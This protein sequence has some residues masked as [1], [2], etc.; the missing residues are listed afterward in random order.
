M[1][2]IIRSAP[3]CLT[4]SQMQ[5]TRLSLTNFRNLAR[6]DIDVPPGTTLILGKNAQGKT[7]ILE[8]IFFLATMST[9][10]A[11]SDRQLINLIHASEAAGCGRAL[12]VSSPKAGTPTRSRCASSR[13]TPATGITRARKEVLVDGVKKPAREAIGQFN[14]V[15]FLPQ[16]MRVVEGPPEERRRY[17][18]LA[19]S[20]VVPHAATALNEYAKVVSNRNALLKRLGESGGDPEQLDFWDERLAKRGAEI[21]H[22][23]IQAVQE[24]DLTARTIHHD[25]TGGSEI[26]R[27]DYQPSYDPADGLARSRP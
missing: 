26:L 6:V 7:S 27:L 25:I 8:A 4:A 20:Q 17:L 21:I 13:K 10:H 24:L 5:L 18:D 3:V 1:D 12:W 19:I 16:M 15:L 9:Y 22:Q 11:S 2:D 14:A 23:R